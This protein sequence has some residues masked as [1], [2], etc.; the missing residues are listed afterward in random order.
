VRGSSRCRSYVPCAERSA[1]RRQALDL[2]WK[3]RPAGDLG[4]P[5]ALP[6]YLQSK[7]DF[8]SRGLAVADL[9]YQDFL[10]KI[11]GLDAQIRRSPT[12]ACAGPVPGFRDSQTG[13][14][15][16]G[17]RNGTQE[18]RAP[19]RPAGF[20]GYAGRRRRAR[21]AIIHL[22]RSSRCFWTDRNVT[23]E[24]TRG[25]LMVLVQSCFGSRALAHERAYG[26]LG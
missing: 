13:P 18:N 12:R 25:T 22:R 1:A 7:R 21:T 10:C 26:C 8:W 19:E 2:N 23:S 9:R 5:P 11:S 3:R 15:G 16:H 6:L 17:T 14:A 20:V 4:C 24:N